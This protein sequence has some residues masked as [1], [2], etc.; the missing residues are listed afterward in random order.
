MSKGAETRQCIG[1]R[2]S[3][4]PGRVPHIARASQSPPEAALHTISSF[5]AGGVICVLVPAGE[6][7]K[8]R[9]GTDKQK[10]RASGRILMLPQ[11]TC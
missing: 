5:D 4:R 1:A 9:S 11:T 6:E 8:E 10:P 3:N 7:N 2:A